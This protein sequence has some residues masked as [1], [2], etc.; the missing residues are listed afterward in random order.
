MQAPLAVGPADYQTA[1]I[2]DLEL[3]NGG[4]LRDARLAYKVFGA[5]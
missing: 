1:M 5:L 2:G 4:V 3:D